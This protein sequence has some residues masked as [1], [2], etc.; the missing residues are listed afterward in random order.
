[1]KYKADYLLTKHTKL[2]IAREVVTLYVVQIL[3]L[4]ISLLLRS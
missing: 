3:K 1:M 4:D 2:Q